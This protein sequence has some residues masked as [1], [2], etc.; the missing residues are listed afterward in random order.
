MKNTNDTHIPAQLWNDYASSFARITTRYQSALYRD[1]AAAVWGRIIDHGC[2]SAKP[3]PYLA[4]KPELT[5]YLGV[6]ASPLMVQLGQQTLT[7]LAD[8]RFSIICSSIEELELDKPFDFA[9]SINS[10]YAWPDPIHVLKKINT[11]LVKGG[12]FI[13][14]TPNEKLDMQGLMQDSQQDFPLSP[15]FQMFRKCND[16]LAQLGTEN[17]VSMDTLVG[18]LR[19]TDFAIELCQAEHF[20]G[21]LNVIHAIKKK[22]GRR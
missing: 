8:P 11:M 22:Q 2:G 5:H 20:D 3:A 14:A 7:R 10:Y 6:D 18:Q 1:I 12:G 13:L 4:N 21:G 19:A 16:L 9:I 15:E 17:F